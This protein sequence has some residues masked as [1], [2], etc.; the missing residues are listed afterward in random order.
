MSLPTTLAEGPTILIGYEYRLQIEADT[1]LFPQ[2][3][4]LA[5]QL[6]MQLADETVI[7]DLSSAGGDL[8]RISDRV[9]E[10]RIAP[11]ITAQMSVGS[12]V[13]DMVR[14]DLQLPR[15]LGFFLEI[16]VSLPVTR[17]L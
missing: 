14:T 9:L 11:Q 15:H 4:A 5:A 6:R 2:G 12:V 13:L 3:A 1:P 10:M 8:V 17:G 7:A 16:P